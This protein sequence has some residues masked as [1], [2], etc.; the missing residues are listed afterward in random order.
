MTKIGAEYINEFL[1]VQDRI[2]VDDM[3]MSHIVS[4]LHYRLFVFS[5]SVRD[6]L[7]GLGE[8]R[9]YSTDIIWAAI[10]GRNAIRTEGNEETKTVAA[11]SSILHQ[12]T[13]CLIRKENLKRISLNA[14]CKHLKVWLGHLEFPKTIK[15]LSKGIESKCD[16]IRDEL[17]LQIMMMLELI[18]NGM[19]GFGM[20]PNQSLY[21]LEREMEKQKRLKESNGGTDGKDVKYKSNSNA[22]DANKDSEMNEET[23][24]EEI[25]ETT[26]EFKF[27]S[28]DENPTSYIR[29]TLLEIGSWLSNTMTILGEIAQNPL[30]TGSGEEMVWR[31][32]GSLELSTDSLQEF[33]DL[34]AGYFRVTLLQALRSPKE[35][36]PSSNNMADQVMAD[37]CI[38]H[39]I[40]TECDRAM[41]MYDC[42]DLFF[43]QVVPEDDDIDKIRIIGWNDG[44]VPGNF[45]GTGGSRKRKSLGS[46]SRGTVKTDTACNGRN[47]SDRQKSHGSKNEDE[48]S[49]IAFTGCKG[50]FSAAI[51]LLERYGFV[52]I[53]ANGDKIERLIFAWDT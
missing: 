23:E 22:I 17:E 48:A 33:K 29:D 7:L 50:R 15:S 49:A 11:L 20:D 16:T 34:S 1:P 9:K 43:K 31:S 41:A 39:N 27:E 25:D 37:V 35:Y 51:D 13:E 52:R 18:E 40:I 46:S 19:P 47:T 36:V 6:V 42:F 53:L 26:L 45:W 38:V 14:L 24:E 10:I 3:R 8:Q 28:S 44:E 30:G 5:I 12:F 4:M 21:G 2:H 32:P